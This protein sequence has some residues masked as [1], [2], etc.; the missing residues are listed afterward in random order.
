MLCLYLQNCLKIAFVALRHAQTVFCW[1]KQTVVMP[2]LWRATFRTFSKWDS[3]STVCCTIVYGANAPL[4]DM[5]RQN[6][7]FITRQ[8][9]DLV[10]AF[11]RQI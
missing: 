2:K 9:V 10:H 1:L 8:I 11:G 4:F 7:A 3:M 6:C 5:M